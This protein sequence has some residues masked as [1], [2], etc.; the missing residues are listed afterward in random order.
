MDEIVPGPLVVVHPNDVRG[1]NVRLVTLQEA[2]PMNHG[3]ANPFSK[4]DWL[5]I[6][7]PNFVGAIPELVD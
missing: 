6:P 4:E 2:V 5:D 1:N 3:S 7:V